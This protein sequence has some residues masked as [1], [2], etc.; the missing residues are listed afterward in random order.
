[1]EYERIPASGHDYQWTVTKEATCT[2]DGK[3]E[4]LCA[5]CGAKTSGEEVII[6][7]PASHT[8]GTEWTVTKE[9]AEGVSETTDDFGT[10]E[11][12][13]TV[14]GE[15]QEQ[16]MINI[17]IGDG[18]TRLYCGTLHDD[19]AYETYELTN[20]YRKSLGLNELT[21]FEDWES[22]CKIRSAEIQILYE[23]SRPNGDADTRYNTV[24]LA[25]NI[26]IT[27][28]TAQE[29]FDGW[30]QSEGHHANIVNPDYKYYYA[31]CLERDDG[32]HSWVQLFWGRAGSSSTTSVQSAETTAPVSED[33]AVEEPEEAVVEE[34]EEEAENSE[35]ISED[36][37]ENETEGIEDAEAEEG[38]EEEETETEEKPDG[39]MESESVEQIA[40]TN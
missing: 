11:R 28:T 40:L 20:E 5:N 9:P 10:R 25:E 36:V 8:W 17:D 39:E 37:S 7:I 21:W 35:E 34:S 14:C 32:A 12:T 33:A 24:K 16:A 1:M 27:D 2:E 6:T 29:V 4:Y 3:E 19:K 38:L 22:L 13:C 15:V 31:A 30:C 18:N 26:S 23:H